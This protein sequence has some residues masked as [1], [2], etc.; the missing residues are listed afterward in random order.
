M[1]ER[2]RPNYRYAHRYFNRGI[3][4]LKCWAKGQWDAFADWAI[5]NGFNSTLELDRINNDGPYAPYNCRFVSHLENSRNRDV[6]HHREATQ[7]G[8]ANQSPEQRKLGNS[9]KSQAAIRR[10]KNQK[11]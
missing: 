9:R 10:W 6:A 11:S 4:V 7:K 1:H 2:C 5:A 8:I 3:R